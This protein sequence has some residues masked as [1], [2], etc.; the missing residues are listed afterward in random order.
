M[1]NIYERLDPSIKVVLERDKIKYK[2]VKKLIV[3]LNNTFIWS[4]LQVTTV[5]QLLTFSDINILDLSGF[6]YLYGED[7]LVLDYEGNKV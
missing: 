6:S 2:T 3:K 5:Q 4:D 7:L 1:M